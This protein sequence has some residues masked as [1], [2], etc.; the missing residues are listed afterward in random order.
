[1]FT[2]L[3]EDANSHYL[4]HCRAFQGSVVN[5]SEAAPSDGLIEYS[6]RSSPE[7]RSGQAPSNNTAALSVY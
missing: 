6:G 1:M 2:F 4:Y 5:V 7:A 3:G